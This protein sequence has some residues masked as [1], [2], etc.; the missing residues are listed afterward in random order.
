MIQT[1][2]RQSEIIRKKET[3]TFLTPHLCQKQHTFGF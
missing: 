2:D 1:R 3:R